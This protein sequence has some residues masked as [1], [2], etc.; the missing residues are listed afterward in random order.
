MPNA[1][2]YV[3]DI[4]WDINGIKLRELSESR[5][6]TQ[7]E[8][9][10]AARKAN[11]NRRVT[12]GILPISPLRAELKESDLEFH[13]PRPSRQRSKPSVIP[14]HPRFSPDGAKP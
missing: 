1:K 7:K 2:V 9:L 8:V 14:R 3:G 12:I 10:N 4:L 11:V 13:S 5:E 6:P